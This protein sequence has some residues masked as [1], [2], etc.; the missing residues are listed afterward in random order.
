VCVRSLAGGRL[1]ESHQQQPRFDA[2]LAGVG[3]IHSEIE[4]AVQDPHRDVVVAIDHDG[5][6]VDLLDA[7]IQRRRTPALGAARER[8]QAGRNSDRKA[9]ATRAVKRLHPDSCIQAIGAA[10]AAGL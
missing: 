8:E 4:S 10:L 3:A 6:A 9:R 1:P 7:R 2:L 5:F